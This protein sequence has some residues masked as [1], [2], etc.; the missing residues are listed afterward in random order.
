[1]SPSNSAIVSLGTPRGQ[2]LADAGI[3]AAVRAGKVRLSFHL[4]NT[5]ADVDLAASILGG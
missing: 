2:A 3:S 1:M 4:Y 5:K